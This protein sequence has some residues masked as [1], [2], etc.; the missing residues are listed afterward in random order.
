VA[1]SYLREFKVKAMACAKEI[2]MSVV[3]AIFQIRS[4][5]EILASDIKINTTDQYSVCSTVNKELQGIH[6]CWGIFIL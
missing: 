4:C 3:K 1:I 2:R 6:T 5:I